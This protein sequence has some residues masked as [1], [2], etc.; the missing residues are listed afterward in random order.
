[1]TLYKIML[2]SEDGVYCQQSGF[3]SIEDANEF[4][5]LY[6]KNYSYP[7]QRLYVEPYKV[8]EEMAS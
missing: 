3:R 5:E 1:M 4:I 7:E 6:S 8:C 2:E